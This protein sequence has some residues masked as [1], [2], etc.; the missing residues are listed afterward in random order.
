MLNEKGDN[1][2]IIF[3][4]KL[5]L[6]RQYLCLLLDSGFMKQLIFFL[7][8]SG[9]SLAGFAQYGRLEPIAE[10]DTSYYVLR[11]PKETIKKLSE[12]QDKKLR[13]AAEQ[14]EIIERELDINRSGYLN[15][16]LLSTDLNMFIR[17][18]ESLNS[19]GVNVNYYIQE[20]LLYHPKNGL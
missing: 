10:N 5:L 1:K 11:T 9:I 20:M 19:K 15:K 8:F 17:Y 13:K 12:N 7:L 18:I 14:I 16:R 6:S 3:K 4:F 2:K